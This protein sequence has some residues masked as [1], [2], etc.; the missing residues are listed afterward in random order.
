M[1]QET[2]KTKTLFLGSDLEERREGIKTRS[3]RQKGGKDG[4]LVIEKG[5]RS[6][7]QPRSE[8]ADVDW[9]DWR[10]RVFNWE[11]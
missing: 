7:T 6:R 2:A 3:R 1:R 5:E 9:W 11:L 10:R 4:G 8:R